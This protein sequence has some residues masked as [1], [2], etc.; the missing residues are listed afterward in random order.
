MRVQLHASVA[1]G[2]SPRTE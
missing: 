1:F 2:A